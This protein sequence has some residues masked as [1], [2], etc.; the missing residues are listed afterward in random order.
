MRDDTLA[1]TSSGPQL[2]AILADGLGTAVYL[3]LNVPLG[4][5]WY[6]PWFGSRL[7]QVRGTSDRWLRL[8]SDYCKEA[9]QW[10][11]R[12]EHLQ[13]VE[14]TVERN[15]QGLNRLDIAVKAVRANGEVETVTVF[16]PVV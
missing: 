1:V 3:S 14:A 9:L 12:G 2:S 15:A 6:A 11:V 8:A 7:N 16:H 4:R 10:L 13:S 5:Y